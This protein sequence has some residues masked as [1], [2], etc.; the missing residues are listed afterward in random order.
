MS[1]SLPKNSQF[2]DRRQPQQKPTQDQINQQLQANIAQMRLNLSTQFLNTLLPIT[3]PS[4]KDLTV[5]L[6]VEFADSLLVRLGI[7]QR[8]GE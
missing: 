3:N 4:D 8:Q 7:A 5:D 2:A 1:N 6:A